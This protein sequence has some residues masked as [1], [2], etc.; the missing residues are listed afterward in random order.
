MPLNI[1][2]SR[3]LS[4]TS[5]IKFQQFMKLRSGNRKNIHTLLKLKYPK[6]ILTIES[7][8]KKNI[9]SHL[10]N[11]LNKSSTDGRINSIYDEN[12]IIKLLKDNYGDSYI[13]KPYKTRH[14]YDVK[15]KSSHLHWI[16]CNIKVST[17]GT[18]NALCKKAL[19]YSLSNLDEDDIPKYM[20]FNKMVEL[21]E[22]NK[23]AERNL[24]KEYYYIYVDKKDGSIIVRSLCDIQ[25]YVSNAQNWLQINWSKEKKV[26]LNDGFEDIDTVYSK[27]RSTLGNSLQKLID[28]SDKLL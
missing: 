19:V 23:N 20:S 6:A 3:Q 5:D 26:I 17:G 9:E 11:K 15:I 1:G 21:I 8:L 18:D 28:S 27:I 25:N 14:W 24:H 2:Y 4:V 16:P 22:A 12:T 7:I 10:L 13:D